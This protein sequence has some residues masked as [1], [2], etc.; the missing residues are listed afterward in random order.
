MA[1]LSLNV[2]TNRLNVLF[3]D[4]IKVG[5][6]EKYSA[7]RFSFFSPKNQ[8]ITEIFQHHNSELFHFYTSSNHYGFVCIII[9]GWPATAHSYSNN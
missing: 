6:A 5:L 9:P 1:S 7:D 3:L 4:A 8:A 2:L